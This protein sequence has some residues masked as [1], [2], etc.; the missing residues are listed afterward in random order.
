MKKTIVVIR[1]SYQSNPKIMKDLTVWVRENEDT[2]LD[3]EIFNGWQ[4]SGSPYPMNQLNN[5]DPLPI[6]TQGFMSTSKLVDEIISILSQLENR[7][8]ES[9]QIINQIKH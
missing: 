3:Y 4:P 2:T 9:Y 5:I 8:V 1:T 7:K 6:T